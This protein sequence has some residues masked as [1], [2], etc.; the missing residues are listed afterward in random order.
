MWVRRPQKLCPSRVATRLG[1]RPIAWSAQLEAVQSVAAQLTR[2]T[3]VKEVSAALCSQTQRVVAFD[4]ARVYVLRAP[5][6][7]SAESWW[8]H[9]VS[10][11]RA[12]PHDGPRLS[13]EGRYRVCCGSRN[14]N[15]TLSRSF[16]SVSLSPAR[17]R[18]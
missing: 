7:E 2:L 14:R 15:R 16:V 18:C 11:A 12:T 8:V 5:T 4:N 10:S 13:L 6:A 17:P 9:A 3:D 1:P